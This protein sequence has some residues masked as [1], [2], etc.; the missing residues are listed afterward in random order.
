MYAVRLNHPTSIASRA[1][2]TPSPVFV[3]SFCCSYIHVRAPW[4]NV[5]CQLCRI[6]GLPAVVVCSPT[7]T[8]MIPQRR[9]VFA[10]LQCMAENQHGWWSVWPQKGCFCPGHKHLDCVS[11]GTFHSPQMRILFVWKA[12]RVGYRITALLY[13]RARNVC[14]ATFLTGFLDQLLQLHLCRRHDVIHPSEAPL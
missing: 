8:L 4:A 14:T 10:Q 11:R 2:T 9:T 6:G 3:C 5:R 13:G 1:S 7:S 12:K